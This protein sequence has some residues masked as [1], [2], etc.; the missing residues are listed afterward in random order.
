MSPDFPEQEV[1]AMKKWKKMTKKPVAIATIFSL[2]LLCFFTHDASPAT[3]VT[4]L[5]RAGQLISAI[6]RASNVVT[7]TLS[8]LYPNNNL[9]AGQSILIS[10]VTDTS[11]DGTFTIA[12]VASQA[13]FTY[14]QTAANASSSGGT[15]G[16]HYTSL[17]TWE[18]G[19]QGNLVTADTIEIAEC[20]SDW[21]DGLVD[22]FTISGWTTDSTRYVKIY[23]PASERHSGTASAGFKLKNTTVA[24][25]P[26]AIS[27]G[28]VRI[29]GL[30]IEQT[31]ADY[32]AVTIIGAD[33][34]DDE[35]WVSKCVIYN[36]NAAPGSSKGIASTGTDNPLIKAWNNIIYD[37]SGAGGAGVKN[38]DGAAMWNVYNNTAYNC[39]GGVNNAGG[40]MVAINNLA[41]QPNS[42]NGFTGLSA[43]SDYNASSDATAGSFGA[44]GRA[45]QAFI[46]ASAVIK[47]FHLDVL[48]TG[49][50]GFGVSDPGAGLF[51][52][53]IDGIS[54]GGSAWDIGASVNTAPGRGAALVFVTQPSGTA[55]AGEAFLIQPQVAV[56]DTYGNTITTDNLTEITL[57]RNTGTDTLQG[58]TLTLPV[59]A[60]VAT[61][62]GLSYNKA[63]I[64]NILANVAMYSV[65]HT[66]VA[67]F[68][69]GSLS[70]TAITGTGDS[71]G[72]V[73][74]SPTTLASTITVID[75]GGAIL[76][77]NDIR[78]KIPSAFNMYWDTTKD[79]LTLGGSAFTS[80]KVSTAVSYEAGGKIAVINVTGDFVD[81]DDL[82][83]SGLY[84]TGISAVSS[85]DNLEMDIYN[86]GVVYVYD[87][88]NVSIEAAP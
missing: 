16:G 76:A 32:G 62:S 30:V 81:G 67:D 4:K 20:Y 82:T 36:S 34:L 61:F 44:N 42:G 57:S 64:M 14:A 86:T 88:K 37:F 51:S 2:L 54:R 46:F 52:D 9:K 27:E 70:N 43:G 23:A 59:T 19:R 72:V 12:S 50:K 79:T 71:A 13:S 10:G 1:R 38:I 18:A 8:A 49:A 6:S 47:D 73:L 80:E 33:T 15:A 87:N 74:G 60:G 41:D 22:A 84:F 3:S 25:V 45:N 77:A 7:V 28:W 63:E 29:E 24:S 83:I 40:A 66:S 26:L 69:G 75:N 31:I 65:F 5:I 55:T 39:Y 35:I 58:A 68:T 56:Q 21:S 85:I 78:I 11:F 48:D 17:T 53:D